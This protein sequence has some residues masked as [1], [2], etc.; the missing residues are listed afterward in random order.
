M[1][2][3][4]LSGGTHHIRQT[5][6]QLR[7]CR[8]KGIADGC[9]EVGDSGIQPLVSGF[10]GVHHRVIGCFRGSCAGSHL[11]QHRII[12]FCTRIKQGQSTHA[13]LCGGP[14]IGKFC[15]AA[16]GGIAQNFQNVTEGIALLGQFCKGHSR[17]FFQNTGHIT[18]GIAQFGKHGFDVGAC[19]GGGNTIGGHNRIGGGKVV[20]FHTVGS[21]QR[22]DLTNGL[23]Q[24]VHGS[25]T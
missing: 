8:V 23:S 13:C 6:I 1:L 9:A 3:K 17:L 16:T 24:F 2:R 10:G 25:F 5:V 15:C 18:A 12:S 22:N 21:G 20:H 11:T 14:Q 19:F 4:E 7:Q